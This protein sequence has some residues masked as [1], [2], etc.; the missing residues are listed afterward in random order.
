LEPRNINLSKM[1]EDLDKVFIPFIELVPTE[2]EIEL[3]KCCR[4]GYYR[5]IDGWAHD[6]EWETLSESEQSA[7]I[8]AARSVV[9]KLT[10]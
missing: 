2:R 10:E 5:A 1:K 8:N 9:I 6:S 4:I 7:W 3:A